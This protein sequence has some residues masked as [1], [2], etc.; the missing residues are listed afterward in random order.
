MDT[1]EFLKTT[2]LF[3]CLEEQEIATIISRIKTKSVPKNTQV[4]MVGDTSSTLYIIK[5]GSVSVVA[6]NEEGKEIILSTLRTGDIFGELSLFDDKPRSAGIV[7]LENCVLLALYKPDFLEL[8]NQSPK[9]ALQVIKYLCQRIRFTNNITQNLVFMDVYERLKNFLYDMAIPGFDGK[10]VTTKP[11]SQI[12]IAA[13]IGSGREI[14]S[15][16]LKELVE[17]GYITIEKKI[18]TLHKKLPK[19][20]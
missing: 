3:N 5:E 8:L 12:E 13:H 20:R 11:M 14:I 2:E 16:I 1:I 19:G 7:S 15:R 10:L 9:M 6:G 17:G 18:I 4:I